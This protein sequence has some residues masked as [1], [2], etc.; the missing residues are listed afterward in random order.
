M[1]TVRTGYAPAT[2]SA[3]SGLMGSPKTLPSWLFYDEQGDALFQEIMRLPEY[4]IT[5][6]EHQIL[7]A[8]KDDLMNYFNHTQKAFQLIEL[9]AGDGMKTQ[10]LLTHL[11]SHGAEFVY[12]PV[13]L[14]TSVLEQLQ[15]RLK[16]ELPDLN[17]NPV[18]A[19][20]N[21]AIESLN[22]NRKKV[23]LF[24]GANI[25][26]YTTMEASSFLQALSLSFT[27][28]DVALIGFDLKKDPNLIASAYNDS[29]GVT[30][31]FNLNMLRRLNRELGANFNVNNF[32]HFPYYD[33]QTGAARS[34]LVSTRD[35][36]VYI[37]GVRRT[38]R[39]QAWES[40]RTEISQKYDLLMIEKLVSDVGLE[41]VDLFF[42][43]EHYF[44]DVLLKKVG[45]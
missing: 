37:E 27:E 26:N 17:I 29:K 16:N 24:L 36:E 43:T 45:L 6:C 31:E 15:L 34:Y 7:D 8:H 20:Y 3:V 13:D 44:C 5:R 12:T 33:P 35:Q 30:R 21:D 11:V 22:S 32:I 19:N 42:D 1:A 23:I 18:R 39:F 10:T 4:Y 28:R 9:G 25:G 2:A 38:I 14:S 40:I 41:I